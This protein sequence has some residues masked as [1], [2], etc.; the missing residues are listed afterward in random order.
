[1]VRR[2]FGDHSFHHITG[3]YPGIGD[4]GRGRWPE[5]D[6]STVTGT[7]GSSSGGG[8]LASL[9][10]DNQDLHPLTDDHAV[11]LPGDLLLNN[12]QPVIALLH[13]RRFDLPVHGRRRGAGPPGVLERESTGEPR[14]ADH[15]QGVGKICLSLPGEA[16]DDVGGDRGVGHRRPY[17]LDDPEETLLAVGAAHPPQH[18]VRP[19]LQRHVQ[20][21]THSLRRRHRLD[22]IIG[23][24]AW[25][26]GGE[27]DALQ[28]VDRPARAQ[29]FRERPRVTQRP[30]IGVHVLAE[31]SDLQNAF[32][33]QRLDLGENVPGAT[34]GLL[35]AQARHD[36][37]GAGV[38]A[39][40]T[41][42]HPGR[43]VCYPLGGKRAG[44]YLQRLGDLNLGHRVV[45]GTFQQDGQS[46]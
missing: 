23:E 46:V 21:R 5:V 22:H 13:D 14:L 20:L 4:V 16:D 8:V 39:A 37:E 45:P 9:A 34:V 42:T 27:S 43:M 25:M 28:A 12:H 33:D 19:R 10:V 36:A 38:V 31:Q 11:G 40:D 29:Q 2:S 41:D 18:R 35:A 3:P 6:K 30:A 44:E 17:P 7:A 24:I 15:L 26:R 32:G 1:M